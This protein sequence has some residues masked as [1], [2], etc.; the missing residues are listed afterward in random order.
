MKHLWKRLALAGLVLAGCALWGLHQYRMHTAVQPI[1]D[2]QPWTLEAI[3]IIVRDGGEHVPYQ[4]ALLGEDEISPALAEELVQ[5]VRRYQRGCAGISVPVNH[6]ITAD[7]VY[8][9]LRLSPGEGGAVWVN[10]STEPGYACV[11]HRDS[12]MDYR[13][14]GSQEMLEETVDILEAYSVLPLPQ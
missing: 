10:L 4:N 12:D 9:T 5:C 7:Y 2:G 11:S 1:L 3:D 6:Y 8:L 13:I 14:V